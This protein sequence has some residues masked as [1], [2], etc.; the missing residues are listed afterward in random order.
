MFGRADVRS[1]A[2]YGLGV[3]ADKLGDAMKPHVGD[4]TSR[5][6]GLVGTGE[7]WLTAATP[8]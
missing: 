2:A 5:L 6:M 8:M 4:A 1:A 7:P 3:C